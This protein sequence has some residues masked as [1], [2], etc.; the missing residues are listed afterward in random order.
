LLL[1]MEAQ[2]RG[3]ELWVYTPDRLSMRDGEVTARANRVTLHEDFDHYYDMGKESILPLA[4]MDVVLLRQDPPFDVNYI[5][6]TYLLERLLPKVQV[7]NHPTHV[8]NQP[9]KLFPTLFA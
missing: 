8:R 1:G 2:K 7:V 3:Y 5:T 9:E 4:K 6:T